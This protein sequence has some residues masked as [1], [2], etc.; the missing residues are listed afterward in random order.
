M[1]KITPRF[2]DQAKWYQ[3]VIREANLADY[4]PVRGT[5]I[6]KPY[7]YAIWEMI[8]RRLDDRI[9]AAGVENVYFPLFIPYSFLQK[10][11]EH[12]EGFAPELALVTHG[13]GKKLEEPLVVR[14]T[15]E[16]IM[17]E[18]FA[19]WI[20]SY[21]DLPLKINQ[22]AN[23][24]RWEKR[25]LPFIRGLEFLW[26]EGHT[27]HKSKKEAEAEVLRALMMYRDFVKEELSL[28]AI[29]GYKTEAEKFAGADYTTSIEVLLKDGK[30]L[31][32]GTSHMLGQNFAKSFGLR[33]L[34]ESNKLQYGWQTSWG[35]STRII[36]GIILAHG[37]DKGLRL[38]PKIAPIQVVIVPIIKG[39]NK[40][41]VMD[42]VQKLKDQIN[43][44]GVRVKVDRTDK[45]AG[46]KFNYWEVK[47]V[48]V[49]IEI[50]EEEVKSKK[51]VIYRRDKD[52]KS[53]GVLT[54][55]GLFKL[56]KEIQVSLFE[57]HKKFTLQHTWEVESF[58]AM[59]EVFK[60]KRGFVKVWYKDNKQ[61]EAKI[62]EVTGGVTA[63]CVPLTT[64]EQ[65][66]RCF[67]SGKKG[68]KLTLFAKAY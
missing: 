68:A 28:Y 47:G 33:F 54:K 23:V 10:E 37:D 14:P 64:V 4:G 65:E 8:Q 57:E 44:W 51:V 60:T 42:Y 3:D 66:G 59:Q 61:I 45:T 25:T 46:F 16:T 34:D 30:A 55:E 11:K 38:P 43:Q 5:I 22:W 41:K 52:I 6:F 35:L 20:Q 18:A 39:K 32:A 24:V 21:R 29:A 19:R 7:G 12:V 15:S 31:Q 63:R 27:V 67:Y 26:Q 53:R 62:K 49:R 56:L 58:E 40:K 13:G 48:P 2:K 36:G 1:S 9:K 17:Y 50:G